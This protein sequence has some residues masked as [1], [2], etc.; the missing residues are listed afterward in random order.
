MTIDSTDPIPQT[1]EQWRHCIE[2]WCK[3]E[4]TPEF[5]DKRLRALQDTNDYHT[6]RFI[7]C[8]G[9][10]HRAAVVGWLQR[11]QQECNNA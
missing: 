4:I 5:I 11:A 2:H 7:E 8:Y 10:A 1:F 3:I 6:R 9:E